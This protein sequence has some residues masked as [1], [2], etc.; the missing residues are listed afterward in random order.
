MLGCKR[1][2]NLSEANHAHRNK[3]QRLSVYIV[4]ACF[5]HLPEQPA[6]PR[7]HCHGKSISLLPLAAFLRL[8]GPHPQPQRH[9]P[10]PIQSKFISEL[11]NTLCRD[12]A[13]HFPPSS[14]L[15]LRR[16]YPSTPI[17]PLPRPLPHWRRGRSIQAPCSESFRHVQCGR[18]A[19]R[20]SS[21]DRSDVVRNW[22]GGYAIEY[23]VCGY[24][25]V[26]EVEGRIHVCG[27]ERKD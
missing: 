5:S 1:R 19:N 21:R 7:S 9:H 12:L 27:G 4:F 13:L 15:R 18:G 17:Q 10:S 25:D 2:C 24:G 22:V 14:L 20:W 11:P 8:H 23:C 16:C 3:V 6:K 26:F